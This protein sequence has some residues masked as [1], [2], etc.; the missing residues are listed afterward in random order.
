MTA[1][2]IAVFFLMSTPGPGV[3]S[4]AG[5]GAG[6][7][8]RAGMR[9]LVGLFIGTN[10]VGLGVITGLAAIVLSVP[11][12]RWILMVLS[13]LYLIYLAARIAFAGSRI[14]FV[15]AKTAPGIRAGILLQAINPKAYVVN[16]TLFTGFPFAPDNL[17]FETLAKLVIMNAIWLPI[18]V[19][20]LLAGV[21]LHR[22]NLSENTQR[23]INY[24]MA[25]LMLGVVLLALVTGMEP[26]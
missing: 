15:E 3:L 14:A 22:L 23:W 11:A 12:L 25:A 24:I 16:T 5:V 7:G 18:H 17:L 13:M 26:K 4:L 21:G 6:F 19:I 2:V 9:Y 10:V 8:T 20:W 1:F